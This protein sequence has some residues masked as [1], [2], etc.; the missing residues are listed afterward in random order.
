MRNEPAIVIRKLVKKF[1]NVTAVDDLDLDIFDNELFVLLGPNGSGKTT[2]LLIISTVYK[3]TSGDVFV[4]GHS[5]L[6]EG[7]KVRKLIGIAF[8]DPKALWMD[9]AYDIL[10]WH[11]LAVGYSLG[12]AKRVVRE[13][14]E[15]LGLWEHRRKMMSELSGGSRKKIEVA[16]VLIQRPKVAIFDEPTAQLDV[17]A[18]HV[19]WKKI[20]EM[21]KEGSTIIIATNDMNEAERLAERIG[22]IHKG[23]LKALGTV[24]QLKD[25]IPGGDVVELE[26]ERVL[27]SDIK[28]LFKEKLGV[29]DVKIDGNLVRLYV[30]KGEEVLANAVALL[31]SLKLRVRRASLKEPTLDDVFFYYTG[32]SLKEEVR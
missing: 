32:A 1:G 28:E 9:T 23:K 26:L 31:E 11:A 16:K 21:K 17:I 14:M 6:K 2:T 22:I 8:Q 7:D 15:E 12:D 13:I 10:L 19:V 27:D 5:V 30:N 3:P 18:R 24:A 20:I 25:G 29:F 4:Y